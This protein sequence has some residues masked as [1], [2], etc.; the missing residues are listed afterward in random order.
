[1]LRPGDR[2]PDFKLP[3]DGGH[4]VRLACLLV[5][6][7]LILYFYPADFTP[8]CTREACDIRELHEAICTA[9]LD[10]VGVSPQSADSHRRFRER[11]HLPF[12]LLS[13][14]EKRVIRAYGVDGP[15]GFGVRRATFFV[16][17]DGRI[18]N[19]VCADFRTGRH[20]TFIENIL[21]ER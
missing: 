17:S 14:P 2:A 19:A 5:N 10:V 16:H 6:G 12:T 3:G 8:G 21:A 13:D 20:V 7:P 11:Y 4:E 1:M 9:G 15:L 18:A